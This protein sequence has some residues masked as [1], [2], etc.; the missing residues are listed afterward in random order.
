MGGIPHFD[1]HWVQTTVGVRWKK[2]ERAFELFVEGKGVTD[3]KQKNTLLFHCGG[4][5]M[6]D[7]YFTFPE[8]A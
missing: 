6:Q 3:A 1:C 7:I 4:M 5:Q 8:A 2:R